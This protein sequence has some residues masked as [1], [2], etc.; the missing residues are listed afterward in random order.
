MT[1]LRPYPTYIMSLTH[2]ILPVLGIFKPENGKHLDIEVADCVAFGAPFRRDHWSK[3]AEYWARDLRNS[4]ITG[5][6]EGSGSI[7]PKRLASPRTAVSTLIA[8]AC[9]HMVIG[10]IQV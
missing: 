1:N 2:S 7:P 3:R 6:G 8:G 9:E 5:H 4:T 10:N